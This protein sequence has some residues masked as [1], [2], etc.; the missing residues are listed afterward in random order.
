MKN[1][2]KQV[3]WFVLDMDGTFYLGDKIIDGSLEFLKAVEESGKN[4]LFLTNNSSKSAKMYVEKLKKMNCHITPN[5]VI[6]SG[7]VM[8]RFL[9]KN[10]KGKTVF[11]LGTEELKHSFEDAGILLTDQAPDIVVSGFDTSLTYVNLEKAC[12][13]IRNGAE[14]LATHIDI[15]CPTEDGYIPD[16]GAICAAITV[17]TG[18]TPKFLG[19]PY[20]ETLEFILEITKAEK[21][22]IAFVGDR[23]YTD[24]ATGVNNGALGFLVLTGEA[25]METVKQSK[26]KPSAIFNSL[27]HM[28]E[29]L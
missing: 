1:I 27:K 6:T 20:C 13:Y 12:T 23:I 11:L 19:K 28:I 5:Q 3:S 9:N 26:V 14:F 16:C 2:L 17:S 7:D 29:F 18:K 8:I 21:E 25:D 15:N 22:E 10:R 24:V 4:F